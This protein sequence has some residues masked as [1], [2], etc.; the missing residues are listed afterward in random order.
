MKNEFLLCGKVLNTHG[1]RGLLKAESYCDSPDVM[2]KLKTVY[3]KEGEDYIPHKV[4]RGARL[5]RFVLLGLEG[6]ADID[7]ATPYKNRMLYAFREDIPLANDRVFVADI[8]G[9]P[10]IDIDTGRTYGVIKEV[11]EAPASLLYV[12]ETEDGSVLFPAVPEFIKEIDT[13]R[14][15]LIRPI[16]GFFS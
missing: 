2:T 4:I 12:I 10:I 9:L 1:V 13:D 5:G 6:L 3:T 8:I 7:K 16:E 14:G 11:E 15:V